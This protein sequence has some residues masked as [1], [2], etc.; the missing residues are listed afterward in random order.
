MEVGYTFNDALHVHMYDG[1][2][3]HGVTS[4]LKNWGDPS[5]LVNWA[6]N[7]AVEYIKDNSSVLS[8]TDLGVSSG[9]LDDARTAHTRKRD[10]AGDK[11]TEV[12]ARLEEAMNEWINTG[13]FTIKD[14]A[15]DDIVH[16]VMQWMFDNGIKP[17]KSEMPVYSLKHFYAGIADGV[18]EKDG[19]KYILDFKTSG[20]I[21][22]K[23]F[24]QCAAYSVAIKEMKPG[25]EVAGVVVVH[26]PKGAAFN[27]EKNI[28]WFH[29]L[30]SIERMWL[31]ILDAYK[32]D[33]NLAKLIKW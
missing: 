19:K 3:M 27:A 2:R 14:T 23:A 7:Q 21:Q 32:T 9:V 22:T 20:S 26:I 29:D 13:G 15:T 11:G 17:L 24:V 12:H 1:K 5:A 30:E 25:A 28:Y 33:H 6:A 10:K 16:R 4:V 8:P 18:I 31:G